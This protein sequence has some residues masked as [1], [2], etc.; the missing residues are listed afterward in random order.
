MLLRPFTQRKRI[1]FCLDMLIARFNNPFFHGTCTR[2]RTVLAFDPSSSVKKPNQPA[3]PSV[4]IKRSMP[5]D[6]FY[7][8]FRCKL[9]VFLWNCSNTNAFLFLHVNCSLCSTLHEFSKLSFKNLVSTS[10]DGW[11][12]LGQGGRSLKYDNHGH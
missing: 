2:R 1:P 10:L 4:K 5:P 8:P 12:K 9:F 6:S 11:I 7:S 3:Y